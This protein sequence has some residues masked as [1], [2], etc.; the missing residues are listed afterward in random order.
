M[1][2]LGEHKLDENSLP[3]EWFNAFLPIYIG[4]I[5]NPH[6]G[7]TPYWTHKWACYTNKKALVLGAGVP[8]ST[9]PTFKHFSYQ[10]I[11]RFI[12]TP[13]KQTL[14]KEMIF[15]T[16]FLDV[17]QYDVTSSLRHSNRG[18]DSARDI[19]TEG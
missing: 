13:R 14:S 8:G 12:A 15:V 11:E 7:N 10:E 19:P 5:S 18:F 17:M 6:H 3:Q 1:K 4:K 16:M 2:F 9:Y